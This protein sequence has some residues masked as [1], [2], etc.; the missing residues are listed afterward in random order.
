ME[1]IQKLLR[2]YRWVFSIAYRNYTVYIKD[3][4]GINV[5]YVIRLFVIIFFYKAIYLAKWSDLVNGYTLEQVTRALIFVQAV[6]VAKSRITDEVNIDIRTGKIATYLLNP[7]HYISYKFFES[8]SKSIYNLIISL[9]IGL[10]LWWVLLGSIPLSLGGILWGIVLLLGGLLINFFSYFMIGLLGFY[11]E[12]ADSFRLLFS[13]MEMFFWGNILPLPFMPVF[14]QTIA[15]LSPFAYAGYT[16]WLIF[17][18]FTVPI[19][20]HY[21]GMQILWIILLIG[22]CYFIYYK[23]QKRLTINGG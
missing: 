19:F 14:L 3:V 10:G 6:V 2:Q 13:R 18:K 7:I 23:A 5:V 1:N 17:T 11:T 8:F 15:F 21:V 12:D 20:I 4:I 22:I 16:A 9:A